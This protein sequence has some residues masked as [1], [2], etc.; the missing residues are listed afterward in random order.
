M[1]MGTEHLFVEILLTKRNRNCGE[2]GEGKVVRA[3]LDVVWSWN[4]INGAQT[5]MPW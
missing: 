3:E 1:W 2:R 5:S 4:M